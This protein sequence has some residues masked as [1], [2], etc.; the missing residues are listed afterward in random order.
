MHFCVDIITAP[1]WE[2]QG[3]WQRWLPVCFK[4]LKTTEPPTHNTEDDPRP[5]LF[6]WRYSQFH[7]VDFATVSLQL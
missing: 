5:F 7:S 2:H 3:F 1:F 6:W 4:G